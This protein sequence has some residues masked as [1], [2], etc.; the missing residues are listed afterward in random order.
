LLDELTTEMDTAIQLI[1]HDLGV[2]AGVCD[3]VAVMYAG[4]P[5]EIAPVEEL[6]YEPKHPYTVGLMGSIPRLGDDRDRLATIPG[7]MPDLVQVPPGC[8]FHP[9]CPYAEEACTGKEPPL[10][11]TETG[12]ADDPTR[13]DRHAAACLEYTG[14]LAQGLDFEV[15]VDDEQG[16]TVGEVED[17]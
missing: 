9:R 15:V 16:V 10:V 7:T 11:D 2:V 14:D 1:T 8:S 5:V 17:A 12:A 4:K 3:R 6:Y 13:H